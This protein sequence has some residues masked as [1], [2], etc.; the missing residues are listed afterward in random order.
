MR[1]LVVILSPLQ[2]SR[3]EENH[4]REGMQA[5]PSLFLP[6]FRMELEGVKVVFRPRHGSFLGMFRDVDAPPGGLDYPTLSVGH[7]LEIF[8]S[9]CCLLD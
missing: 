3:C 2:N 1:F 5:S 4:V 6:Q 8:G 7:H 9:A